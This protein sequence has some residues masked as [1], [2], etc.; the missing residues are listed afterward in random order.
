MPAVPVVW[1]APGL[2][3]GVA[4]LEFNRARVRLNGAGCSPPAFWG[5]TPR[6]DPPTELNLR[7]ELAFQAL[8]RPPCVPVPAD[9]ASA[10]H[11]ASFTT[12]PGPKKQ[13]KAAEG[14]APRRRRAS[15]IAQKATPK[16]QATRTAQDRSAAAEHAANQAKTKKKDGDGLAFTRTSRRVLRVKSPEPAADLGLR[17]FRKFCPRHD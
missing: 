5:H 9:A 8:S 15:L 11:R 17:L 14:L 6:G 16:R 7:Q 2:R 1:S 4:G 13:P 12:A 3:L 10:E